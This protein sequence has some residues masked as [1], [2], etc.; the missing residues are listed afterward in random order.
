MSYYGEHRGFI[1]LHRIPHLNY[2]Q[3]I[4]VAY[5]VH[6]MITIHSV[7]MTSDLEVWNQDSSF[8]GTVSQICFAHLIFKLSYNL[9]KYLFS[10]LS[11]R[12]FWRQEYKV[13]RNI[14]HTPTIIYVL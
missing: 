1:K 3:S 9:M 8:E 4:M 13:Y 12:V 7:G 6:R 2:I 5:Y 11:L 10:L 14:K